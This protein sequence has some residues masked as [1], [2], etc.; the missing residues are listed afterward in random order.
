MGLLP[1]ELVPPG[2]VAQPDQDLPNTDSPLK[3]QSMT[4]VDMVATFRFDPEYYDPNAEEP[5]SSYHTFAE[6]QTV[7]ISGNRSVSAVRCLGESA[8]RAY[9]RGARTFAG[10][11]IFAMFAEDPLHTIT[12]LDPDHE[13]YNTREPFFL[14]Q[15][16]EFDIIINSINELG[17]PSKAVIGG[18]TQTNDCTTLSIHDIDTEISYTYVA[19]FFIPMSTN[20]RSVDKVRQLALEPLYRMAS[21]ESKTVLQNPPDKFEIAAINALDS[22]K[23]NTKAGKLVRSFET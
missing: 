5:K 8:A 9:T 12:R 6:I 14:D 20:I 19:R 18:I 11:L 17:A 13:V 7:S 16:P 1:R 23:A 3:W 22:N 2:Y 4:G 10:T 15:I 21:Q